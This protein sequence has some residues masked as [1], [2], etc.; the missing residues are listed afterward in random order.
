[1]TTP[2]KDPAEGLAITARAFQELLPELR[3]DRRL[4]P[5]RPGLERV[6][7][8]L[9]PLPRR[10]LFL[11]LADDGLPVL[12]DLFDPAPGALL[13]T[14]D[15]GAGKTLFLRHLVRAAARVQSEQDLQWAVLSAHPEQWQGSE[16]PQRVG[17]FAPYERAAGDLLVSLCGWAESGRG[18]RQAVLLLID[19]LEL[20]PHLDYDAQTHL[21]WLLEHGP[22]RRVWPVATVSPGRRS[23][24][25]DWLQPFRTRLF[26]RV[27]DP[28]EASAL[29]GPGSG[30]EALIPGVQFILPEGRERVRFWIA[31]I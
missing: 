26:G 28:A 19:G 11:G 10:A 4:A 2:E 24:A 30:L 16:S 15:P 17:I 13:L 18:N 1:M 29:A 27:A 8:G 7:S 31:Q 6:L 3:A 21:R 12:L 25:L 22:G 5:P 14:A 9:G 23:Q 20:V